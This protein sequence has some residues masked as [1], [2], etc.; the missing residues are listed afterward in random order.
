MKAERLTLAI[1]EMKARVFDDQRGLCA[2]CHM[3]MDRY[4]FALAHIVP[5]RKDLLRTWGE[6]VIHHRRNVAVT[7]STDLC[8]GGVQID[9][10]SV[11]A[12]EH[13]ESIRQEVAGEVLD[14]S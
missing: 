4:R 8:N 13:L 6:S 7:H 5:Q 10:N 3:P 14:R 2:T 1:E 12:V 11:Q 9:P